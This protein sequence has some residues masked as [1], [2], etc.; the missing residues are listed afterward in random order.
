MEPPQSQSIS[1]DL[2]EPEDDEQD[3]IIDGCCSCCYDCWA[4]CFDFLFCGD[5]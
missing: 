4:S 1:K 5:H 3:K 2:P